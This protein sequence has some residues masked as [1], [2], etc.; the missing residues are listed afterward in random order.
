M[1]IQGMRVGEVVSHPD[2]AP[3]A[4]HRDCESFAE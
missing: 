2:T 4:Y 3:I 1:L